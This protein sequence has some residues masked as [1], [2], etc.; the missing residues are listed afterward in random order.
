MYFIPVHTDKVALSSSTLLG[1]APCL[2]LLEL[3]WTLILS[4]TVDD[5]VVQFSIGSDL[6]S[7]D[8]RSLSYQ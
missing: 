8:D 1:W 3:F 4:H 2:S 5:K 6:S 7:Q